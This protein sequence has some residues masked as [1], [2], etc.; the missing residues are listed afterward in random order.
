MS[1]RAR[2][3]KQLWWAGV[4]LALLVGLWQGYG[5]WLWDT[6]RHAR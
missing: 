5:G 2:F 1:S 3:Q 6:V 4:A